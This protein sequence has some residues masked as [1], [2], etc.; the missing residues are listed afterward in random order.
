MKKHGNCIIKWMLFR[1]NKTLSW[2]LQI[3]KIRLLIFH[4]WAQWQS[5]KQFLTQLHLAMCTFRTSSYHSPTLWFSRPLIRWINVYFVDYCKYS[6]R[7]MFNHFCMVWIDWII[8]LRLETQTPKIQCVPFLL[9]YFWAVNI[10]Y[11][12]AMNS[13]YAIKALCRIV[14]GSHVFIDLV[15]WVKYNKNLC[16]YLVEQINKRVMCVYASRNKL[17]KWYLLTYS[18]SGFV[19]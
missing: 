2:T 15:G 5:W 10:N 1:K 3:T 13:M 6:G 19:P 4:V 9:Y 18:L 8:E 12:D 17:K 16:L 7:C 14:C 11:I